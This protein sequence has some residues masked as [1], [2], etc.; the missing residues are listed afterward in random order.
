MASIGHPHVPK[1]DTDGNATTL[2]TAVPAP[3]DVGLN[4]EGK[5]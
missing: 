3:A 4:L 5:V 1:C 2:A